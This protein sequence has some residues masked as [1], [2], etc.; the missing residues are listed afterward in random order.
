MH[1]LLLI[2]LIAAILIL[3][4][5][6]EP[7][8]FDERLKAGE[9]AFVGGEYF[10][11]RGYLLQAL[12]EKP[13]DRHPLYLLGLTYSRELMYDSAAYYLGRANI[14]YPDDREINLGLYE[15]ALNIEDWESARAAL[16][17][18]VKTGDPVES[19]LETLA[20]LSLQ[21]ED[22]PWAHYYYGQLLNKESDNP[23]RWI[24]TAN[25][26]ADMGSLFVAIDLLDS[27]IEEFGPNESFLAN[28]GIYHAVL[29]QYPES[30]KIFRSLIVA[31]TTA[32]AYRINLASALAS[33]PDKQKKREALS[34]Y[35]LA[36]DV[37][38]ADSRLDSLIGVLET[39]LGDTN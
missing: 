5:A 3:A 18:L 34:L 19:H 8:T 21:M 24:Q 7:E 30:E 2:P 27:A 23:N 39:E 20:E 6:S 38:G 1:R 12:Q 16:R 22:L 25:T 28:K 31:D 29:G 37:L 10:K 11:A 17:V 13:S 9:R 35:F 33:Q 4:C 14:L 36:R 32:I 26:A 15:A